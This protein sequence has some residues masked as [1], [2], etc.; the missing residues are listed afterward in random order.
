VSS[1]PPF[2]ESYGNGS[3]AVSGSFIADNLKIG[4]TT[5][6]A[7]VMALVASGT[8]PPVGI[9]GLGFDVSESISTEDGIVYPTI[10]DTMYNQDL[11]NSHAYSLYLDDLGK[12][13]SDQESSHNI[14]TNFKIQLPPQVRCYLAATTRIN[15]RDHS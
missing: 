13:G 15:T 4:D 8:G 9:L 6:E 10:L 1:L 5:V 12:L 2:S 3:H 11:I 14:I 7:L